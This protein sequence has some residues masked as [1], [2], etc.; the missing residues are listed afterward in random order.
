M[1]TQIYAMALAAMLVSTPVWA[2]GDEHDAHHE[3]AA[4]AAGSEMKTLEDGLAVLQTAVKEKAFDK[5]HEVVETMEPALKAIGEAHNDETGITGTTAQLGKALNALHT[6]G[7]AKDAEATAAALKKLEGGIKLLKSRL[8]GTESKHDQHSDSGGKA[9][10]EISIQVT[11]A[12]PLVADKE[13]TL[14]VKLADSN[15]HPLTLDKLKEVHTQKVHLLVA[16]ETLGDYHH[17]HPVTGKNDGEYVATFIPK[18]ATSYKVWADITP[19]NG[20]QKFVSALVKGNDPCAASCVQKDLT[21]SA[22]EAGLKANL[23]FEG[24]LT[25]GTAVMGSLTIEDEKGNPVKDLQPVMGAFAH[26]VGFYEDFNSVAH[27]HPMGE[28]PTKAEQRGGPDLKFHF[29][30][31]RKGFVKLY[32]QV[33]RNDKDIF[34]PFGIEVE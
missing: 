11:S 24:K 26:I 19:V 16:D 15:G 20:S 27:I 22:K 12:A 4:P 18:K 2:H 7:D 14:A 32:A 3:T 21:S 17:L 9:G 5:I 29:E 6:S 34:I 25:T 28:E 23:S 13:D 8:S 31:E 1:K 10:S 33:R 30:P